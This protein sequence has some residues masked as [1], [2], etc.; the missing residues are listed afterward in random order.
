MQ[1]K[2]LKLLSVLL[3]ICTIC[4]VFGMT[5]PT[6]A[7]AATATK[8]VLKVNSEWTSDGA[9][10]A[11]YFFGNGEKWVSMTSQGNNIYT[12]SVPSGYSSVIFVRMNGG[13]TTNSWDNKWNQSS[14]LTVPADTSCMYTMKSGWWDGDV[15]TWGACSHSWNSGTVTKQ[16]TCAATGVKTYTCN[17]CAGTKTETIAKT[18]NHNYA[19]ATCTVAKKCTVCG[20]T[21]GSAL[22]HSY[23]YAKNVNPTESATGSIK[24]TCSRC[25]GTTTVSLPKLNTS[26][27]TR[28]QTK[29]PTCTATGTY[30]WTWNTK[31]YGTFTYTSSIPAK[32]HSYGNASCSAPATCSTCGS[33]TGSA[34]G[35]NYTNYA[36]VTAPT[37]S[38]TGSIKGKCSR[39]TATNTVT[40]PALNTTNYTRTTTKAATCTATGT[41]S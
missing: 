25:K 5:R 40:L 22:G 7:D 31:T 9:R 14:D 8:L 36:T 13:N 32:G 23:S 10:F 41:Y 27:Y 28:T 38:A 29:A 4:V 39:C 16:A 21:S 33:T 6:E 35:H 1:R 12:C 26:N 2:M 3:L 17:W 37:T 15:G 24:G 11:A 19:A 20:V 30:S 18:T 34:L